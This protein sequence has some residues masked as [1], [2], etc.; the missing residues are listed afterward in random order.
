[1][2][3]SPQLGVHPSKKSEVPSPPR[4]GFCP[5]GQPCWPE[6]FEGGWTTKEDPDQ[7]ICEGQDFQGYIHWE[8]LHVDVPKTVV[9]GS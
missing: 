8:V 9:E 3:T 2:T 4:D 7:W 5:R 6:P 1:M